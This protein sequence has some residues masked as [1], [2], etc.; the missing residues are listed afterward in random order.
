MGAPM[1]G[2]LK[3][4]GHD[5]IVWNRTPA[6]AQAWV[7]AHGGAR[8]ETIAE[9]VAGRD[10]VLACVGDD[11]DARAV[12]QAAFAAMRPGAAYVDHTTTSAVLARELD[13]AARARGLSF[14][15]APVSGGQAGAQNGRLT[16]MCGGSPEAFAQVRPLLEAHCATIVH[17]GPAGAGQS[18]KMVNQIAIAGVVQGLAEAMAF[19]EKQGLDLGAVLAAVGQGAAGS[20]QMHNR[21]PTM[22]EGRFDFGF[23]V[24]WMRKDLRIV[25]EAAA[26][27]GVD[28]PI[29]DMVDGFY[30]DIQ[31]MG[32]GRW[33]TSSLI[34]RLRDRAG[35]DDDRDVGHDGDRAGGGGE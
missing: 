11:P 13:E 5:V 31:A 26:A 6:K 30:S 4:K 9:A 12:A 15:D 3:A 23:A 17:M 28:L 10:A 16:A 14:V 24:D 34:V 27:S 2:W 29:V 8:A 22:A 33:D 1:A 19:A 32:G 7:A 18:T 21:W 25:R 35:G 20:W